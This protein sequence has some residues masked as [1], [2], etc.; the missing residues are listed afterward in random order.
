[1]WYVLFSLPL[2]ATLS[3]YTANCQRSVSSLL[4]HA[5]LAYRWRL[6]R[7]VRGHRAR[8]P[9]IARVTPGVAA[10]ALQQVSPCANFCAPFFSHTYYNTMIYIYCWSS[11]GVQYRHIISVSDAVGHVCMYVCTYVCMSVCLYVY[12]FIKVYVCMHSMYVCIY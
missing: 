7:G 11:G 4:V 12:L 6:P 1:M 9:Q 10:D 3:V 5:L 8:C 2:S